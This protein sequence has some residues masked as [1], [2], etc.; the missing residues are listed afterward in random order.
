MDL[1][2]FIPAILLASAPV[3]AQDSTYVH[4]FEDK[5]SVQLFALNTSNDFAFNYANDGLQVN[6]IPNQKTT[7][8][9]GVQYDIVAFSFGFAPSFFA[10]NRD[11]KG[12]KMF[13]F[14]TTTF[15]KR[16]V[17]KLEFFYQR[18]MTLE[19]ANN[20]AAFVYL[21][22]LKS[23][24]IGGSTSYV[25]NR[26]FSFRAVTLQNAKQ[27]RSQGS[28]APGLS[29]YYTNLDG[30]HEPQLGSRAYFIDLA[31][32]MAYHYN[33]VIGGN[34]LLA[35]GIS[36]GGGIS[37]TVDDGNRYTAAMYTGGLMFA[38][39]YNAERWFAGAQIRV[40]YNG[41][42]SES[43]VTVGDAVGYTTAFVGYR[44]EAPTFLQQQKDKIKN[45]IKL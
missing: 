11:N 9:I 26:N 28:F 22:K 29:Y 7:L 12:S 14:A 6:L 43:N 24:K 3:L 4:N 36:L 33:W 23:M 1:T 8:N 10:D 30:R 40:H 25:L 13:S 17:Q 18:G 32:E 41:H 37:W 42:E 2:K 34:F 45:K 38:P 44:F 21:P 39:G 20:T 27:L 35:S 31:A 19:N 5:L 16:F 15:P